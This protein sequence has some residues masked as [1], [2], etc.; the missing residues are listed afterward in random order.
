MK[1]YLEIT[2]LPNVE[3]GVNFLLSKVLQQIH[4][5][6]VELQDDHNQVPIG[7]SFPNY[8]VSE[9]DISLGVKLR[10]F[11]ND[12]DTLAK[13][14]ISHWLVRLRDY[15]HITSIRPVPVKKITGYA[16]YKREQPRESKERL[17]RRYAKRKGVDYEQGLELYR[18]TKTQFIKLPFIK[19]KSL[20]SQHSFRLYINK[21]S[22]P[23][24]I[25]DKFGTYGLSSIS[26]VPEF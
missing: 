5:S 23:S 10:L 7:I 16:V 19:I 18:N 9:R 20:S 21:I 17:A 8:L 15:V 6:L 14:K 2:L 22:V 12:E 11:A 24:A 4:L 1:Y 26:S 13:V 3:V 25:N